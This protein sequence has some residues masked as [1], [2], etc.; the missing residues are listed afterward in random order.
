MKPSG[1]KKLKRSFYHSVD[2][3]FQDDLNRFFKE[4]TQNNHYVGFLYE[5]ILRD[6][7]S[8]SK[9][10]DRYPEEPGLIAH[11]IPTT[12]G[13]EFLP[14]HFDREDPVYNRELDERSDWL[15]AGGDS[16]SYDYFV[17]EDRIAKKRSRIVKRLFSLSM[18]F[19]HFLEEI[20]KE[21]RIPVHSL[22][23]IYSVMA[24]EEEVVS[25]F[26]EGHLKESV[27]IP[28]DV[29]VEER[30]N[31]LLNISG[32]IYNAWMECLLLLSLLGIIELVIINRLFS[33][34]DF[35]K[36]Q[37]Y[38]LHTACY[39]ELEDKISGASSIDDLKKYVEE[40]FSVFKS[41]IPG[42]LR[43]YEKNVRFWVKKGAFLERRGTKIRIDPSL[44]SQVAEYSDPEKIEF[45]A[46]QSI[47]EDDISE[48][49]A[50]DESGNGESADSAWITAGSDDDSEDDS[51][52]SHLSRKPRGKRKTD[53]N[54][55]PFKSDEEAFYGYMN[56][57]LG[58]RWLKGL[59]FTYK[60]QG[61]PLD[62]MVYL[63]GIFIK[64]ALSVMGENYDAIL[65]SQI[66]RSLR[67]ARRWDKELKEGENLI[68]GEFKG[69]D[70]PRS[71]KDLSGYDID[72]IKR[73][74][75]ERQK[76]HSPEFL[77]K[78]QV[79]AML[80]NPASRKALEKKAGVRIPEY[81]RSTL[82]RKIKKLLGLNTI[83]FHKEGT[84]YRFE[85]SQE[86][87]IKIVREISKL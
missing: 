42:F 70:R 36:V 47:L 5:Q 30:D 85:K 41:F 9:E 57:K 60:L 19:S 84:I 48:P 75:E 34:N 33:D 51:G 8:L 21:H 61:S 27:Q 74:K 76:H 53:D 58:K 10:H 67:T 63:R 32:Q 46:L 23:K 28:Q 65:K 35:E 86:N 24:S 18:E 50:L 20:H 6:L 16:D 7:K 45:K 68:D 38:L 77:T 15:R 25:L 87:I 56:L 52:D 62:L 64:Q 26:K 71:I 3:T 22:T 78:G 79:I 2:K 13:F 81:S 29:P 49:E 11:Y 12:K 73:K 40:E 31:L 39:Y 72:N 83:R 44:M 59:L 37:E 82:K 1:T 66:D 69:E 54:S 4:L 17:L 43:F 80:L 14:L 55:K